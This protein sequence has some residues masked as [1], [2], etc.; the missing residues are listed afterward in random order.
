GGRHSFV[1]DD[2]NL[3]VTSTDSLTGT[4]TAFQVTQRFT[5]LG[6]LRRREASTPSPALDVTEM[7]YDNMG[8]LSQQSLPFR[9]PSDERWIS[10]AYDELG[11]VKRVTAADNGT[12]SY[13]YNESQRPAGA[14]TG[15][16]TVRV[17]DT[18]GRMR[19]RATDILGRLMQV[20][21]PDPATG[22]VF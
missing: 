3:A 18:W 2:I 12:T 11:R 5:G 14:L 1:Y 4:D 8:R 21:E 16:H 7:T 15:G 19:W 22:S 20:A 17:Q 10:Y 6:Q 13:F 9:F